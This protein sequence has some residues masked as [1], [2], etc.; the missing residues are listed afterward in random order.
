MKNYLLVTAVFVG[1]LFAAC[2]SLKNFAVYEPGHWQGIG[3]GYNGAIV[4]SVE[5]DSASIIDIK[6]LEQNEDAMIGGDALR[7]LKEYVLDTDS[8]DVDAVSGATQTSEGFLNA[9]NNA[10]S[11]A[12]I[13]K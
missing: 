8:T 3:E 7:A 10:L 11:N 6:V 4:V 12:R 13:E 1:A 2:I 9:V 5:T